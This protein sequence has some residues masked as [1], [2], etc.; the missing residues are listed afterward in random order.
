MSMSENMSF[1]SL[2]V[3]ASILVQLVM[4]AL[5]VMSLVSW[6]YIFL[7]R[8]I[9][10]D[11]FRSVRAFEGH[12]ASVNDPGSLYQHVRASKSRGA[13]DR[14]FESALREFT[15]LQQQTG[16]S[17]PTLMDGTRRAM[18]AQYQRELDRL[19]MNLSFLATVGSV[20]PYVGLFGTVWGIMNAFRGL[21]NVGQATLAQVA[22]GIA[23]A[24]IA[25]A[26]GL[27]AAI[28]AVL[29]YNRYVRDVE[30]L[31]ARYESG[32]EE[33][34]NLLQRSVTVS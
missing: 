12:F 10:K 8:E 17:L 4:V 27:F 19:E 22:P 26:M 28:P 3:N 23:E 31:T 21:A 24:L 25:T 7:K 16:M 18:N 34:S 9:F 11:A 2:I 29:A 1:F 15:K 13:L 5:L 14:I 6:W 32:M 30:R 33:I 20:S